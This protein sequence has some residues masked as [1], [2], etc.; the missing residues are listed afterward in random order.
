M[1]SQDHPEYTKILDLPYVKQQ[2]NYCGPASLSM[3]MQYFGYSTTQEEIAEELGRKEVSKHGVRPG[4]LALY[5]RRRG[6]RVSARNHVGLEGIF[7]ALENDLPLIAL[8]R[9]FPPQRGL[10]YTIIRGYD[11][12]KE[13][14][15]IHDPAW[16]RRKK[17]LWDDFELRW[18]IPKES[19]FYFALVVEPK[20]ELQ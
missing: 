16:P 13:A 2:S 18:W 5:A 8:C 10:H 12:D 11:L 19:Y 1:P 14:L 7:K 15:F 3:V 9:A 4:E 20:K 17:T 6:M